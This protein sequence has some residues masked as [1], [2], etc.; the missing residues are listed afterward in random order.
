MQ[1]KN[2]KNAFGFIHK[3]FHWLIAK[4]I[5]AQFAVIFQYE[6]LLKDDPRKTEYMLMHKS[7]GITVLGLALLFVL[8]RLYTKRPLLPENLTTLERR[9]AKIVHHCFF[10][11]LF[12]MPLTGYA[13]STAAGRASSWFGMVTLPLLFPE[14]KP[15]AGILKVT[16][17]Y[18]GFFILGLIAVHLLA[19]FK[20]RLIYKDNVLKRMWFSE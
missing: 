17:E 20:H 12:L 10:V 13:M 1:M 3:L 15:L 6:E 19:V 14:N 7:I 16:H 9:L 2:T 5:I 11:V 8:W 4:L 18:I